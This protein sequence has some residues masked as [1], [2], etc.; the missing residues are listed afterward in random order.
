M[1][2]HK[3]DDLITKALDLFCRNH[4]MHWKVHGRGGKHVKVEVYDDEV[5]V[6]TPVAGSSGDWR[7]A[8]NYTSG[9]KNKVIQARESLSQ[10]GV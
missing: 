7:A 4:A 1:T 5:K 8:K 6:I 10:Q 2:V 9:L 3:I